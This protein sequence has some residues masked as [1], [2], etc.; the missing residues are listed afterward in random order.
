MKKIEEIQKRKAI[1]SYGGSG[2]VIETNENGSLLIKP[3][4][5]WNCFCGRNLLNR[6][7]IQDERLLQEVQGNDNPTVERL[8]EIP[9]L[10]GT[11]D[12]FRPSLE[13]Q[14]KSIRA[15]YFPHWFYCEKC[16]NLKKY[17]DWRDAWIER[18]P[19]D[20]HGRGDNVVSRFLNN[21]PA[22]SNCSTQAGRVYHRKKLQQIRFLMASLDSGKLF[23]IP[24]DVLFNLPD[25]N[26]QGNV[27]YL[28]GVL[29]INGELSYHSRSGGDGLES[30]YVKCTRTDGTTS[31]VFLSEIEQKYLVYRNGTNKGAYRL[32]L[33]GGSDLYFPRIT[34]AIYIPTFK[35]SD[36]NFIRLELMD[37]RSEQEIQNRGNMTGH[38]LDLDQI[39]FIINHVIPADGQNQQQDANIGLKMGEFLFITNPG[40]YQNNKIT[41]PDFCATRFPNLNLGGIGIRIQDIYALTRLKETSVLMGYTR[42]SPTPMRWWSVDAEQELDDQSAQEQKPFSINNPDFMPAVEAYGEGLL[43][44]INNDGFPGDDRERIHRFL[45]TYS[46]LIIKELEF[47]CGYPATSLKERIYDDGTHL[48]FLIYAIQGSEGSYGGLTSLMPT[49]PNSDGALGDAKIIKV[50]D[51]AIKRAEDCPNDP[52]C[53]ADGAHCFACVDLPETSCEEWNNNLSRKDFIDYVHLD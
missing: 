53:K 30:L 39:H 46:H 17:S 22:C 44:V 7:P 31:Q 35:D 4:N 29:P 32:K 51:Q 48:G 24:F 15:E 11:V 16:R 5:E 27:W 26:K 43:F 19:Q 14:D 12:I 6:K 10:E 18:F 38:Q 33:R 13:T 45:H 9:V 34:S 41:Q 50:I 28:D 42:V 1:S 25:E 2:S 40:Y 37:G 8:L 3:Y 20:L 21:P 49:D 23:D 36:V 47:L 52:I